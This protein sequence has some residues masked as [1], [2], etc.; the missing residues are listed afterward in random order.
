MEAVM[1]GLFLAG[2]FLCLLFQW[3]ILAAIAAGFFL[4][5]GYGLWRRHS[6]RELLRV[7]WHSV[8]QIRQILLLFLLIGMFTACW[9]SAGT[10]PLIVGCSVQYIAP[11]VVYLMSFCLNCLI[12]VLTG[13]AFVTAAVMG[14]IC[15]S[16]SSAMQM[17]PVITGGAILS[18]VYFGDRCSPVS[19]SALLVAGITRT[20]IYRNLVCMVR[21]SWQPF[22]LSCL[23]YLLLATGTAGQAVDTAYLLEAAGQ[24]FQL[25]WLVLLPVLVL[26]LC[27]AIR[28]PVKWMMLLSILAAILVSIVVQGDSWDQILHLLWSGYHAEQTAAAGLFDGGGIYSMLNV[29]AIVC[30][31]SCYAGLFECTGLLEGLTR[32]LQHLQQYASVYSCYVIAALLTGVVACNQTL[33]ILLTQQLCKNMVQD[34][35]LAARYLED[36][37]VVLAAL[38]PWSIAGAVP[39]ATVGAPTNSILAASYLYLLPCWQLWHR[40]RKSNG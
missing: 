14:V 19:T 32:R 9:R 40:R 1:I 21:D 7:S 38:I 28:V 34:S 22:L 13:T 12:S 27:A 39:L 36:S 33:T 29:T 16:V 25:S 18:G 30:L 5:F 15:M 11:P 8:R 20:E 3:P 2:L 35:Q 23:V 37:A 26:F 17:D 6:F 24:V 31:A 10:I 4:F